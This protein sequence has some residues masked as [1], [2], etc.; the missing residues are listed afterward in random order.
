MPAK[1]WVQVVELERDA[2]GAPVL[3]DD[4]PV[5]I[6]RLAPCRPGEDVPFDLSDAVTLQGDRLLTSDGWW[7]SPDR[8][9]QVGGFIARIRDEDRWPDDGSPDPE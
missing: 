2:E 3:L 9:L 8:L 6:K 5:V 7:F 4:A 1:L